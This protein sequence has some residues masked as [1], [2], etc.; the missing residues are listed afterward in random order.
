MFIPFNDAVRLV[1][2]LADLEAERSHRNYIDTEHLLL[3][4]VQLHDCVAVRVMHGGKI[5]PDK[6]REAVNKSIQPSMECSSD[7]RRRLTPAAEKAIEL[8]TAAAERLGHVRVGTGHLLLGLLEEAEG[9]AYRVLC[10]VGIVLVGNN[11]SR[12]AERVTKEMKWES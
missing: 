6:V 2:R 12:V 3:G 10:Q 5:T 8:A 4:L 7:D 1:L 11:L 9:V